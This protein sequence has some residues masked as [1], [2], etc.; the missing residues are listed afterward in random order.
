MLYT[1]ED[2]LPKDFFQETIQEKAEMI[3]KYLKDVRNPLVFSALI[4]PNMA[5]FKF[6]SP[7]EEDSLTLHYI[8]F[9]FR[10]PARSIVSSMG[11]VELCVE[12]GINKMEQILC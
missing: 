8:F 1:T 9:Q 7:Q 12:G 10:G 3:R 2:K 11:A 4:G 5:T 6:Y